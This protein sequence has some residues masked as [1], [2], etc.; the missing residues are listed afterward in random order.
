[1]LKSCQFGTQNVRARLLKPIK[2]HF[3]GLVGQLLK[4]RLVIHPSVIISNLG[5]G[6]FYH[7]KLQNMHVQ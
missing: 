3:A 6:S 5:S 1:M 7:F 4:Y 2:V